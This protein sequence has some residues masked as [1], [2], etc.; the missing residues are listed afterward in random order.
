MENELISDTP[1]TD[2]WIATQPPMALLVRYQMQKLERQRNEARELC[3]WAFPRLRAMSYDFDAVGISWECAD[4]I[5][6]NPKIFFP[7]Q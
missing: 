6:N 2:E 5:A 3:R 7:A 4:R 1:E